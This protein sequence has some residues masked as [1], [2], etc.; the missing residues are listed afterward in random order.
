MNPSFLVIRL[1]G[2]MAEVADKIAAREN[3]AFLA[4]CRA[5]LQWRS[6]RRIVVIAGQMRCGQASRLANV[7]YVEALIPSVV[8][9]HAMWRPS[10]L[11]AYSTLCLRVL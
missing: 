4:R 11:L 10:H 9:V 6:V 1:R 8:R 2:S 7:R 5:V 3:D